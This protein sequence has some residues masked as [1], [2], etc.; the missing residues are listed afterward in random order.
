MVMRTRHFTVAALA[1]VAVASLGGCTRED[2]S[3]A[4]LIT[5]LRVLGVQAE[6]PEADPGERVNLTAWVVDPRGGSIDV[7]WSACLLPSNGLANNDCTS[8][9]DAGLM[10]LGRG[11][12][13]SITVPAV[14]RA[15][16]GPPDGT[17]GV[18]LPL[19]MHASANGDSVDAVY[20]LRIHG[21]QPP[22][23]NP[24]FASITNLPIDGTF[25][26]VHKGEVW[27][28]I[29]H[30]TDDSNQRYA[31][32]GQMKSVYEELTTQWFASAGTFPNSPVGGTGVQALT[33]DRALPSPGGNIDVWVV[34]HDDRGGTTMVHGLL[35]LP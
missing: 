18:Y 29:A 8:G 5:S 31:I 6:P 35:R 27:P 14:S 19:V 30:Y 9:S 20:R 33:I 13:L 25:R 1:I 10:A 32:T 4:G 12:T 2:W 24:Q 3:D 11:I 16:L 34:G 21:D 26:D 22:N 7:T 28:M 17:D 23:L 15:M